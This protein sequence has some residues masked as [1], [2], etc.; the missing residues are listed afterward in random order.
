MTVKFLNK[1]IALFLAFILITGLFPP[2]LFSQPGSSPFSE[3]KGFNS[4]VFDNHFSKADRE[5]NPERWLTEAKFGIT[6]AVCAW[7]LIAVKLYDNPEDLIE[8]KNQI[9]KWSDDE[10][11]KRFSEW[12]IGRFFGKAAESA[13]F[14]I[15]NSFGEAQK[16][17]I[18][19]LDDSG[20][21]L[22][23]DQTGDPLVIRPNDEN[24]EFSHDLILWRNETGEILNTAN[25][26]FE[27]VITGFFP[28]L[29]AYIPPELRAV[30]G[31]VI[32]ETINLKSINLKNEF[33]NI[34]A[35][36]ERILSS[37]RTRD[38]W[39][40]RNKS[41]NEAARIFTDKL[42]AETEETCKQGIK[43]L[44]AK[45]EQAVSGS[46][47]LAVLGEEWLR[48]YQEQFEK[49]LNAW[50][51]AEERFFIRR[52]EWEQDSIDMYSKGEE[53]W[54]AAFSQFEEERN[55]WELKA[56]EL[57]QS[58][59]KM[60]VDISEEFNKSIVKAKEEFELNIKVRTEEGKAKVQALIDMY[61]L[62]SSA[63]FSA[64]E[65]SNFWE[66]EEREEERQESY[67]MY[68]S[69]LDKAAEMR[70]RIYE[71]YAELFENGALK[72]ILSPGASSEDFYLDEYQIA[73]IKAKALVLYW[74]RKT[75]IA[76]SVMSYAVELS[77]GRLTEAEGIR[78]WE[79][80][81]TAYENS[82]S[83]YERE[84]K[85]L[86]NI[87]INLE[88]QKENL[89][90]LAEKMK[91][92]EEILSRLN[93]DYTALISISAGNQKS[94]YSD[95]L[96][97]VYTILAEKYKIFTETGT[98]AV[99]KNTLEYGMKWDIA[100]KQQNANEIKKLLLNG[101][102]DLLSLSELEKKVME[103]DEQETALQIRLAAIDLF[104]IT[105]NSADW[106][107]KAKGII[108]TKEEKTNIYGKK[109]YDRLI[110]D[111]N[112]IISLI[113]E[114]QLEYELIISEDDSLPYISIEEYLSQYYKE[115][116][117]CRGLLQ[118]YLDFSSQCPFIQE[119]IWQNSCKSFTSLMTSYGIKQDA[120]FFP[121]VQSITDAVRKKT[122]NFINNMSVFI[123]EIDNCFS[124]VP[125]WLEYEID[126]WRESLIAYCAAYAFNKN[127][128]P[129][130]DS[131]S[132]L[133][134]QNEKITDYYQLIADMNPQDETNPYIIDA[135]NKI[136]LLNYTYQITESW[137]KMDASSSNAEKHWRQYLSKN[138]IKN[139]DPPLEAVSSWQE[140]MLA[141]SFYYA[142]YYTNRVND[143]FKIISTKNINTDE[144]AEF[145]YN[146]YSNNLIA[147]I[148]NLNSLNQ[149]FNELAN[150]A[151]AYEYS[152]MTPA[153]VKKEMAELEEELRDQENAYNLARNIYLEAANTFMTAGANYDKQYNKLKQ[154][155]EISDQKRFEYEKQD[156]IQRWASTSYLGADNI[157]LENAKNK[158]ARAQ[159]VL[160]VLTDIYNG[161]NK[162]SSNDPQYETL[163]SAYK[164]SFNMKMKVQE[165][166]ELLSSA[167][168]Y[169]AK[170][171]E[172]LFNDY[173]ASLHM[174]GSPDKTIWSFITE[175]DGRL[176]FA[177]NGFSK[178]EAENFFSIEDEIFGNR[179]VTGYEKSLIM[180]SEGISKYLY[181][182]KKTNSLLDMIYGIINSLNN[183]MR[184]C[185]ARDYLIL[186]LANGNLDFL[187]TYYT[188]INLFSNNGDI[189]KLLIK[190][191]TNIFK[192]TEKNIYEILNASGN[193]D[194]YAAN[195]KIAW[196][197]LSKEEQADLE[198][199]VILTLI[200]SNGY[201]K[202]FANFYHSVLI[203]NAYANAYSYLNKA[204][205]KQNDSFDNF[206]GGS[207]LDKMEDINNHT[208]Y[209]I[210]NSRAELQKQS[211]VWTEGLKQNISLI[212]S[213]ALEYEKSN[214]KLALLNI[215]KED[216]SFI[217][218]ND[219]NLSLTT[220]GNMNINEIAEIKNFWE[221]MP[222]HLKLR[223]T[224]VSEALSSLL[225]WT[226]DEEKNNKTALET[227]WQK[228]AL[229]QKEKET[230]F[231]TT[232]ESYIS[233]LIG[234]NEFKAEADNTYRNNTVTIKYHLDNMHSVLLN[235][236]TAYE[237]KNANLNVIYGAIGNELVILSE[238]MIKDRYNSELRAREAEWNQALTG[239]KDKYN[240]WQKSAALILENGRNDWSEG[241]KKLKASYKQWS[242]N[243]QNEYERVSDEWSLAYLA[244]LED[245]EIWL[246]QAANA[247]NQASHESL[248]SLVGT[249]GERLSRFVD[250]R[251]PL[252]I[253]F[254]T[255]QAQSLMAELLQTSGIANM[256]NAFGSFK[257]TAN[258][259]SP[260][261]KR[262][263]GGY[264]AWDTALVKTAASDLAKKTNEEIAN[265]ESR[266]M[267]HYARKTADE[268]IKSL[269]VNVQTANNKFRESMDNAFIINGLWGKNGNNYVKNILKG[270]T[271]FEPVITESITVSGYADYKMEPIV[272]KTKLDE[273]YLVNLN[274][275]AINAL[276]NNVYAEIEKITANIFGENEQSSGKFGAHVGQGPETNTNNNGSKSRSEILINEGTGEQGRLIS[277]LIYWSVIENYGFTELQS[278]SWEKRL[279]DDE[280]SWFKS[281]SL[282]TVGVIV[283]SIAAGIVS[284][285]AGFVAGMAIA[286]ALSSASEIVF[287]SLD[288]MQ[289]YKT[290]DEAAFSVGK[291]VLTNT[292]TSFASGAFTGMKGVQG[293]LGEGL[294][295]TVTSA[296]S[297]PVS[298]IAAQTM[299]TGLQT[300]SVG[301][302]SSLISGITYNSSDGFG[303]SS[304]VV[305]AGI[306][307]ILTNA[308]TSMTT[309]LVGSSLTAINSGL[310]MSKLK[311]FN[312]MNQ[313]NLNK[314]NG[315]LGSLAGQGV[316]Y[317]MGNDFTLNVL[318][319]GLFTKNEDINNGLLELHLGRDGATMNFGTG[320]ANVSIDNIF[321]S[322]KGAMVWNTNNRID[323]YVKSQGQEDGN[324]FDS[325]VTL[326]AQYGYGDTVQKDQLWDILGGRT[327]IDTSA[328]G[329]Y[330]AKTVENKDTRVIHL[331]NYQQGM[332]EEAQFLL[333]T[334]FGHEA[335]RDG[336]KEGEIN[337]SGNYITKEAS[338]NELKDS[339]IARLMMAD[340]INE[341]NKW[342]YNIFEGLAYESILL[343]HAKTTGNFFE[344]DDY[345]TLA[346]NN[347][348]DYQWISVNN[349]GDYQNYYKT[350]PLFNSELT[351]KRITEVNQQRLA[352][353]FERY[354]STFTTEGHWQN[355][356]VLYNDFINNSK[357]QQEWGYRDVAQASIAGYGCMFMSTKNGIEAITGTKINPLAL[358]GYIKEN[359]FILKNTD[360][361][362]SRDLMA[363][364]MTEY[365]G[366]QYTVEYIKAFGESP[367]IDTLNFIET[368]PE[369]YIAHLRVQNPTVK[370]ALIHS[371]MVAGIESNR[372][373][374]G[375][376]TGVNKVNVANPL[377]PTSHF[378]TKTSYLPEEIV[379]WD[380]FKVTQNRP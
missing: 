69:Y 284:G 41:E 283:G 61:L 373:E 348:E 175:K 153:K 133:L 281:P 123:L 139:I 185:Q 361:Y 216:G 202:G 22:F 45:I 227:Y 10:L 30:M 108:L 164:Q 12:L 270:S 121:D 74:E 369:L 311:G 135:M 97:E 357:L 372:S 27:N 148:I 145:Y 16:N 258:V 298:T 96:N 64:L 218:W 301:L 9:V 65:N 29:L 231:Q 365:T 212:E 248:L 349:G 242:V 142:A 53:L 299:M 303:Y 360:N 28:E 58:G 89:N 107:S 110:Q 170:N 236:L 341:E 318:N 241:I 221:K 259:S 44:N 300:F 331:A 207:R 347:T 306:N 57:F 176:A 254:E 156:S 118:L 126:S 352:D 204:Q 292:V 33:E 315:L 163:Y 83:D 166:I 330:L 223:F 344:F 245:K 7:E 235:Q 150:S 321:S 198:Y 334:V 15:S 49:G 374:T 55:N 206:F 243:F 131:D 46:G 95:N 240:E 4:S 3:V 141:D 286:V 229:V 48:M 353:A 312:K 194:S 168:K 94:F 112:N 368:S 113:N 337:T 279:W 117:L 338:F 130:K 90:I 208:L 119:E 75:E 19:R 260:L 187:K 100:E 86:N 42:I 125:I 154:T 305:S 237:N 250:T 184:W 249:E 167:I 380:F 67:K 261:L 6:Q 296:A 124:E 195:C 343:D 59:E 76:E 128:K 232:I 342:F 282:R 52:I 172:L 363:T 18:W 191:D 252:G 262:G 295:K 149:Y 336:Y 273:D 17:Y 51:E 345:L 188:G 43:E 257:N 213:N 32:N 226:E 79:E 173:R 158:L 266:K 34:A 371:V 328:E 92:E 78:A 186:S 297:S 138:Y 193:I 8:A 302:S 181:S 103:G 340:R 136:I 23:D 325:K 275:I 38:I 56:K 105:G 293:I 366:R 277:E 326:R 320:G 251:E 280:G 111:Y 82:L 155:Q 36:E 174:L 367:S 137:E 247:F 11:E 358:H 287:S 304:D 210:G 230:S 274:S 14:E 271:V 307:G 66:K 62:C 84:L 115:F 77:A 272:L 72:D 178:E 26:S 144:T 253:S 354:S 183:E 377:L 233:G 355:Y 327:L 238:K 222:G 102:S 375:Q 196:D 197:T 129:V 263:M 161:E 359:N 162:P 120:A 332:N 324:K 316:N 192:D 228:S 313:N 87:G 63:A 214:K 268:A 132:L 104:N 109:L 308:L 114:K 362:L 169:E 256:T 147:N 379:R 190:T 50:E 217:T 285:G 88:S 350:V 211:V 267:A 25:V 93:A 70:G 329:E 116:Y 346:Y 244:G 317:A 151:R 54:L 179:F 31:N 20:N 339:S 39:S 152:K 160:N 203:E 99:Y 199:Y 85:K 127:I 364:I 2:F 319:L 13:F 225:N 201:S 165:T 322:I 323:K 224:S 143:S 351:E 159:T 309:T 278:P 40:L 180:L 356:D 134:E 255:P 98:E 314:L 73:L 146:F 80:A 294:T 68:T 35:R 205:K 310:D 21:I 101:S 60:F 246:E 106:Y 122:G 269:T 215:K 81:K 290:F 200:D 1:T 289:G 171:N 378:N 140:G 5:I 219:I 264:S 47:D 91:K 182:N 376:I 234:I 71:N 189:G 37:R 291:T 220:A 157:D 333:A 239:L 177:N 265:S 24:R 288:V 276:L 335:Y 370:N 209:L